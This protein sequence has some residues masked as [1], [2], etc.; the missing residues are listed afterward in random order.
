[1]A[2]SEVTLSGVDVMDINQGLQKIRMRA[3]TLICEQIEDV[4][5]K[6][7][8]RTI[9]SKKKDL[10]KMVAELQCYGFDPSLVKDKEEQQKL[11][12]KIAS[13][14]AS[15][16]L[17]DKKLVDLEKQKVQIK[18]TPKLTVEE[19]EEAKRFRDD[20]EKQRNSF[21]GLSWT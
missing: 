21:K 12:Q 11:E 17:H 16:L 3:A 14:D 8:S 6:C 10:D 4:I 7:S 20:F 18:E 15:L 13:L 19:L 5:T 2:F 1:M 9:L